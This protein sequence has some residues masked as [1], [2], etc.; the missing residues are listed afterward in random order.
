MVEFDRSDRCW[1]Q[2]HLS[3]GMAS[4]AIQIVWGMVAII[5]L[6]KSVKG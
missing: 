4:F 2:C 6:I 3:K 5:A 1:Y